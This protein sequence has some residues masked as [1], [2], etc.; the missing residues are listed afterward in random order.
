MPNRIQ[1]NSIQA[2]RLSGPDAII[3]NGKPLSGG[4][5]GFISSG[6]S[7]GVSATQNACDSR[8]AALWFNA[9][10]M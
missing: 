5:Y 3:V 8:V 9:M 6:D 4:L 2:E 7:R 10:F 1:V